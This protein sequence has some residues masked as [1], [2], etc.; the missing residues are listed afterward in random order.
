MAHG[1]PSG[2]LPIAK[3]EQNR[4]DDG[5]HPR[6][7]SYTGQI[8]HFGRD[9]HDFLLAAKRPSAYC[10]HGHTKIASDRVTLAPGGRERFISKGLIT[11]TPTLKIASKL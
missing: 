10:I 7:R 11:P 9:G 8:F 3:P 5:H 1:L 6:P 2:S 4:R